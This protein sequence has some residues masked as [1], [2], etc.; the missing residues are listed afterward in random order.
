[1]EETKVDVLSPAVG[2]MHGMLKSMIHGMAEKRLNLARIRDLKM[3]LDRALDKLAAIDARKT[4]VVE[5]RYFG[6]LTIEET[7]EIDLRRPPRRGTKWQD[8][9]KCLRA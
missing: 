7:A 6:G 4:S 9:K 3:A 5:L 1:V 2:N 8:L